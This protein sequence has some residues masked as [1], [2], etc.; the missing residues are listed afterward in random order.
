MI[1]SEIVHFS[2]LNERFPFTSLRVIVTYHPFQEHFPCLLMGFRWWLE[3]K[4]RYIHWQHGV[5]HVVEVVDNHYLD[6]LS[7]A[8][9]FAEVHSVIIVLLHHYIL[10]AFHLFF[11]FPFFQTLSLTSYQSQLMESLLSGFKQILNWLFIFLMF[12]FLVLN[13]E[14]IELVVPGWKLFTDLKEEQQIIVWHLYHCLIDFKVWL[15]VIE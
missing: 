4:R 7:G 12:M 14:L 15:L 9:R 2:L 1:V 10:A 8:F 5:K 13:K 11:L 6:P 3:S